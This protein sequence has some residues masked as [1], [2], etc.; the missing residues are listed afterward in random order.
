M[1]EDSLARLEG[2]VQAIERAIPFLEQV[3]DTQRLQVV[4]EAAVVLHARVERVLS[5]VPERRV[6]QVVRERDRLDEIFVE[7]QVARDRSRDLR[8]L[9]RVRQ[10]RAEEIAFVIDEDLRLV[11]E[12]PERRRVN[13]AI[14]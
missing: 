2:E 8:D 9:E 12:A 14:A 6:P 10:P 13:D 5:R 3:D 4:L 11:L 1:L 7:P